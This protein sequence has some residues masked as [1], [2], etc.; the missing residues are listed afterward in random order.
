MCRNLQIM[1]HFAH[2]WICI[3]IFFLYFDRLD[4]FVFIFAIELLLLY[5]VQQQPQ[6]ENMC[7]KLQFMQQFAPHL[8]GTIVLASFCI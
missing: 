6:R 1:Q 5:F 3:S 4:V 8:E 2:T 7:R